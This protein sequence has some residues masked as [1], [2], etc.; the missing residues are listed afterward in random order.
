MIF[1]RNTKIIQWG[2]EQSLQQ[3]VPIKLDIH[4]QKDK[5]EPLYSTPFY[6]EWIETLN[7]KP[8]S[9]KL[10]RTKQRTKP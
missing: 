2:K 5:A 1:D 4:M 8:K 9:I 3:M 10:F 6:S 7:I